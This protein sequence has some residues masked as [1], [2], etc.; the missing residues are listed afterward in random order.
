MIEQ[1][2]DLNQYFKNVNNHRPQE[3]LKERSPLT[4]KDRGS[5][6]VIENLLRTNIYLVN[7][8][9]EKTNRNEADNGPF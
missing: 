4:P 1:P 8:P 3:H 9:I 6:R 7:L 5:S 2:I